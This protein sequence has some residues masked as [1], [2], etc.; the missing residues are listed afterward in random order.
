MDA[1]LKSRAEEPSA[2]ARTLFVCVR[3]KGGK[4]RSC[5]GSGSR[6]LLQ[7]MQGMLSNEGVPEGELRVR[8]CGCLGL[9]KQGPVM[10]VAEGAA[11]QERKPPKVKKA[12]AKKKVAGVYTRVDAE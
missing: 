7:Q 1:K 12:K 2:E 4:G 6:A 9:C 3:E 5:A 11:A 10:V 8:P